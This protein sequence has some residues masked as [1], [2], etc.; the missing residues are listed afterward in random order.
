MIWTAQRNMDQ[1]ALVAAMYAQ[2]DNIACERKAILVGGLRGAGALTQ[3]G[4]DASR[5]LT[6]SIDGILTEMAARGLIP[7]VDGL[8]PLEA[9]D[10][11]HAGAQ[12]LAK[13]LGMRAL[14]DG[15]NII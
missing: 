10:L 7:H 1:G 8:S 12:F 15:R 2:A 6:I 5:Y 4:I 13:R 3:A 9:A 11:A 14:A